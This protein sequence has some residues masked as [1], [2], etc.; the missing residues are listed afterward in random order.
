[1]KP[2]LRKLSVVLVTVLTLGIYTPPITLDTDAS[3]ESNEITSSKAKVND[4]S[5]IVNE[6][7]V[8]VDDDIQEDESSEDTAVE[9]IKELAKA[10]AITKLGPKILTQVE[11]EFTNYILPNIEQVL[12]SIITEMGEE[13]AHYFGITEET[14]A[15]YGERIFDLYDVRT[16]QDIARFHVRREN[17]PQEGFWFN[18]HYH[19]QKDNFQKHYNLGDIYYDKNT[20]PKWMS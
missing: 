13:D 3:A 10:Q 4:E 16:N 20:P 11:D 7:P 14:T 5:T 12:T 9:S 8:I 2:W 18:F 1:M 19:L 17:R 6:N 15:G